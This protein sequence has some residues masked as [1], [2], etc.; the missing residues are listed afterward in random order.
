MLEENNYYFPLYCGISSSKNPEDDLI[1][2]S[3]KIW[4]GEPYEDL[5]KQRPVCLIIDEYEKL[6]DSHV[7]LLISNMIFE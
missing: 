7:N 5:I 4:D 6:K 3:L 2:D 1:S